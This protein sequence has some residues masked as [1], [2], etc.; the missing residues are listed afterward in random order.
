MRLVV[1]ASVLIAEALRERGRTL[2][3]NPSLDLVAAAEAVSETEH[4]LRK[5]VELIAERGD[6]GAESAARLLDAALVM[7]ALRIPLAEPEIYAARLDEA[8]TR[9]PRDERDAPTVALAM[10]LDC[11]IWTA[12]QDFFGCGVAVW[13][14]ETLLLHL[15]TGGDV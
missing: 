11:G 13:T 14:T 2:L 12:D 4:E 10:A 6:L 15:A 5:R 1:D 3:R 9:V 7:I 8:R